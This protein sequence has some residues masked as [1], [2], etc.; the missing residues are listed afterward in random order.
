MNSSALPSGNDIYAWIEEVYSWGIRRPAWEADHK[1]EAYVREA[2][3]RFGLE[4]VRAEPVELPRWE[5]GFAHLEITG[6]D[7]SFE[8]PCFPLP[9]AARTERIQ[10]PL[11]ALG[12]GADCGGHAVLSKHPLMR[13]PA[14][15]VLNAGAVP[16]E[17]NDELVLGLHAGGILVDPGGTLEKT[18]QVLPFSPLIQFV[19][20]PAIEAGARAFI[21]VLE[22]YPGD[23]H[24]YYV[25]YDGVERS[26]PGVWIS[27]SDGKRIEALMQSGPVVAT[28]EVSSTRKTVTSYNIVGELPGKDEEWLVIGT[29]HDGPWASAV[30]DASGISLVLAQASYWAK[31]LRES[32][33]HRLIF[34]VNAGHMVGGAGCHAFIE[35]HRDMLDDIVLSVHLE[36]AANECHEVDGRVVP[37]GRPEARWFF[38]TQTE[39]L[40][41][42]VR[43]ALEAEGL[44]RSMII[45][46]D[47]F[48]DRPTTD[49]GA[50]HLEGV[51]LVD[52]LTAPFYLFDA[53][54]T[55][56]KIHKPSLEPITRATIRIVEDTDG[57]SAQ[58]MR[59][60]R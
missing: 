45:A 1:A 33:P 47:A 30:E 43:Q 6:A 52:Y 4:N 31:Q 22:D 23:S 19:M 3:E 53:M 54:D 25:P 49:G 38:T 34:L 41:N 26:I 35:Q 28:L 18:E 50:F 39:R 27:G 7:D 59:E 2:F 46:P 15:M 56:D 58:A 36:H 13:V 20:E 55:L 40:R 48:G 5:P 44:E 32:R 12:E 10:L 8:V 29:H 9:H 21:G 16:D 17:V 42:S 57:I 37:T 14:T 51:P 24:D 11:M 60:S